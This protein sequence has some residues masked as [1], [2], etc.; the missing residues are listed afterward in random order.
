M[1]LSILDHLE[2]YLMLLYTYRIF[3][4]FFQEFKYEIL[5]F[6]IFKALFEVYKCLNVHLVLVQKKF[7][8][9]ISS[10]RAIEIFGNF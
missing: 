5:F 3:E 8:F 1:Y 7:K 6:M 2:I 10:Y 4:K 9:F